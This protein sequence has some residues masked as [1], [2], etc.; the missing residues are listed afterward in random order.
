MVSNPVGC[1][2][3]PRDPNAQDNTFPPGW[4][5]QN[6]VSGNFFKC[7]SATIAGAVWIP[8]AGMGTGTVVELTG[9]SGGTVGPDGGG[10]INVVGDGTTINIVGNPGTNTLTAS[11]VGGDVAAQSFVTNV[12]GPIVPT[13]AG[14]IDLN[15]S[16][17]T[18]TDGGTANTIKT[19]L[20]GTNHALFVGRGVHSP[21]TTIPT[22]TSSQLLVSSG[23][24]SDPTW[25]DQ[26]ALTQPTYPCFL[27]SLT[28]PATNVTGDTT[29]WYF[30][31][32]G[33]GTTGTQ[34]D[35]GSNTS[36]IGGVFTFTAP[37]TGVY[38]FHGLIEWD[39]VDNTFHDANCS[40]VISGTDARTVNGV[41]L[42][43]ATSFN[44]SNNMTTFC[45]AIV[46]MASGDTAILNGNV[47]GGAKTVGVFGGAGPS[48]NTYF[49]GHMI[50]RTA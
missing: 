43:A 4:E 21:A 12:S 31:T 16:T 10:N 36:T 42:N 28:S 27:A 34:F 13:A 29:I 44:T 45:T 26:S 6:T 40:I 30:G 50:A 22:G 32:T 5:W 3:N 8:F 33:G 24:G 23:A 47:S 9:N 37:F 20:Q 49:E 17:S 38:L 46:N 11:L 18:Y 35:L 41:T 1:E 48:V 2:H 39:S 14:V 25:K 7:Q 15:A 19:E